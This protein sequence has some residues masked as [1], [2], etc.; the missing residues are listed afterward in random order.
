M[1]TVGMECHCILA[2][3]SLLTP[4]H[5]SQMYGNAHLGFFF[6]GF[7]FSEGL[8]LVVNINLELRL[9]LRLPKV[10]R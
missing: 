2:R 9:S 4:T 7:C 1:V 6:V 8:G 10:R 5:G 3:Q